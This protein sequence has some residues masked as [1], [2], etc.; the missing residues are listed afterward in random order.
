MDH[1]H[2]ASLFVSPAVAVALLLMVSSPSPGHARPPAPASANT[3][4]T[5]APPGM[6]YIPGGT[7]RMGTNTGRAPEGPVHEVTVSPFWIDRHE[8]TVAEFARFVE[9]TGHVTAAERDGIS[10]RFDVETGR[11]ED[12]KGANWRHPEGPGSEADPREPVTQV[13]WHD[14]AAYA[15]WAGK[16][17]PTEAE[18]EFAARGG[19]DQ[20]EYAWGNDLSPGGRLMANWWQGHFPSQNLKEDGYAGRAP[21]GQFPPNG[22]GLYDITCNVWEWCADWYAD[23]YFSRSPKLNPAGPAT[24]KKRVVRGGSFLCSTNYCAG[25]RVAARNRHVPET[26]L[27][28]IGF[29]CAWPAR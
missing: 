27:N 11:W 21:V 28:N 19:L 3:E 22:Y 24:G 26:G 12:V 9:A 6:V 14:A 13:S 2:A 4:T 8:V 20:A 25:F 1:P 15:A 29:R 23:D 5:T 10:R 16:R 18:W 17:L 7:F